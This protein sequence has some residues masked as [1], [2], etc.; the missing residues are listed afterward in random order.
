MQKSKKAFTMIELIFVIVILGILAAVA[1]PKLAATRDDAKVAAAAADLAVVIN[2]F[3]SY[4]TA[5]GKFSTV[6]DMTNVDFLEPGSTDMSGGGSLTYEVDTG[7]GV[8]LTFTTTVDGNLTV[9]HTATD[10]GT[11]CNELG[12]IKTDLIKTHSFAG[13][14]LLY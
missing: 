2:D 11:T 8:C 12:L 10:T 5:K 1:L 9:V 7:S 3:G 13:T 4:W 6:D 14:G